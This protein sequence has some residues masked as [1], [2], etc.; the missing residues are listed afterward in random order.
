MF[1]CALR[2]EIHIG[3]SHSLKERRAVLRP[4]IEGIRNRFGVAVAEVG[5]QDTWQ[6]AAIGIAAVGSAEHQVTEVLDSVDRFIWSW[7]EI[8]VTETERTWLD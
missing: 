3:H 2:V 6:R 1:V 8:E 5:F 7:P 4:L